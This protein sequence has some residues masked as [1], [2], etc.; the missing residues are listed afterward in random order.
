MIDA[1]DERISYIPFDDVTKARGLVEAWRDAW[2]SV[3]PE[4]GLIMWRPNRRSAGFPQ[5]NQNEII[6]RKI[7][8]KMYPWAEIRQIPLVLIP[9]GPDEY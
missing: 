1:D 2:W 9:R 4:R 5:C 3:H 6:A 8:D 7:G